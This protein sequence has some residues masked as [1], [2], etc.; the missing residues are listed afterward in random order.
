[1]KFFNL[2]IILMLSLL[3]TSCLPERKVNSSRNGDESVTDSEVVSVIVEDTFTTDEIETVYDEDELEDDEAEEDD[4]EEE[5]A[6][7]EAEEEEEYAEYCGTL[8][9]DQDDDILFQDDDDNVYKVS[10]ED[11][12]EGAYEDQ[13]VEFPFDSLEA[14]VDAVITTKP[15][16]ILSYPV[17]NNFQ[18]GSVAIYNTNTMSVKYFRASDYTPNPL[19][20]D[21][22]DEY[23]YSLCGKIKTETV[24]GKKYA[25]LSDGHFYPN[26]YDLNLDAFTFYIDASSDYSDMHETVDDNGNSMDGCVYFDDVSTMTN[27]YAADKVNSE[28]YSRIIEIEDYLLDW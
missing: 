14:C 7:E 17:Y 13:E 19:R 11:S 20:E 9:L 18:K 10:F 4:E 23:N 26:D 21:V 3:L 5:V 2:Y 1:M 28:T 24:S 25:K 16:I 27:L 6:E 8:Y 15:P 12:A 22:E